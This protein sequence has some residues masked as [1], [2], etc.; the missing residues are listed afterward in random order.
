M[1]QSNQQRVV[2]WLGRG[3]VIAVVAIG[4]GLAAPRRA[5]AVVGCGSVVLS[6]TTLA[7]NVGPC[8]TSPAL[9]VVGPATLDLNGFDVSCAGSGVGILLEGPHAILRNGSVGRAGVCNTGI[10]VLGTLDVVSNV[11]V[12]NVVDEGIHVAGGGGHVLDSN[13]VHDIALPNRAGI[14]VISS[15]NSLTGNRVKRTGGINIE[16]LGCSNT[17]SDNVA[18]H[19]IFGISIESDACP[20]NNGL[21]ILV[22]N[23]ASGNVNTGFTVDNTANNVLIQ[24]TAKSNGKFGIFAGGSPFGA[25]NNVFLQNKATGNGQDDLF[26]DDAGCDSNI[27]L[28]DVFATA[29]QACIH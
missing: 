23:T 4:L 19:G 24:N 22:H 13:F 5:D 8:A 1:I 16:I 11:E 18:E 29:N 7:A 25:L 20:G 6:N 26:D 3:L 17:L 14:E 15:G 9:T 2:G 10:L 27:W 21:N 28:A 12:A